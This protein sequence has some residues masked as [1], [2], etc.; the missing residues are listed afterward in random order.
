MFNWTR[1]KFTSILQEQEK[2]INFYTIKNMLIEKIC[3]INE[4]AAER[5]DY[6]ETW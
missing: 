3:Y 1:K 6:F 4:F 5:M 2:T